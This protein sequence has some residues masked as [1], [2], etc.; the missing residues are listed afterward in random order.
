MFEALLFVR[1][2]TSPAY[3]A[4]GIK[5][6]QQIFLRVVRRYP[7]GDRDGAEVVIKEDQVIVGKS[8]YREN[9]IVLKFCQTRPNG[10]WWI[11]P[12]TWAE[13]ASKTLQK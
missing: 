11:W 9:P 3:L 12:S 7:L 6:E 13:M 10:L 4:D 8:R 2:R 5:Q 1:F